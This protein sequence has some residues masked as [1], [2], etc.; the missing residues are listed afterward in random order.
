MD[1]TFDINKIDDDRLSQPAT[2]NQVKALSYKFAKKDNGT[3]DWR[4]QKQ[5]LGCLYGLIKDN[6]LSFNQAHG[7]FQKK[8]LPKVFKDMI[9]A[10]IKSNPEA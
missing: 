8:T 10:Y 4:L 9:S 3:M 7:L 5:L 1:T 6:K 2:F